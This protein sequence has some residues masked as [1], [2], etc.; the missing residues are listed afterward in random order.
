MKVGHAK[1]DALIGFEAPGRCDHADRRWL[2]WVLRR[3]AND[4]VVE[5][6]L[7]R[8]AGR[9]FY[10]KV[11]LQHVLRQRLHMHMHMRFN[12]CSGSISGG[13][14]LGQRPRTR[15]LRQGKGRERDTAAWTPGTGSSRRCLS[16][17]C[18]RCRFCLRS[19]GCMTPLA[20]SAASRLRL[21]RCHTHGGVLL[22]T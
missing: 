19:A 20:P 8:R 22:S 3:E 7:V 13:G 15:E 1:A 10:A 9:P 14:R 12:A 17:R 16:S 2:E 18:N 4:A 11:P 6:P 21:S 5:A